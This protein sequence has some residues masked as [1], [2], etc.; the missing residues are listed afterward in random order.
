[1]NIKFASRWLV[2]AT[3]ML[4]V[5]GYSAY[6]EQTSATAFDKESVLT[7]KIK[8]KLAAEKLSSLSVR[9]VISVENHIK[10][11]AAK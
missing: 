2:V 1:M 5:A 8:G 9:G 3:L 7:T 4:P 6:S 11:V 10:I